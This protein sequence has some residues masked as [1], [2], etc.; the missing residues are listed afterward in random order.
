MIAE[1][2][3]AQIME[4][5]RRG[6]NQ[7]ARS[8]SVNVL[9]GAPFGY[10]YVRKGDHAA[11]RYEVVPHE[12]AIV[13]GLFRRYADE[14]IAIAELAR[15]LGS[16][17]VATRTG[18]ARWDRSTIWGMLRNP[19]Y[20]G[21]ACFGKTG[22]VSQQAGRNRV[23]RL[24][25]RAAGA[26]YT[27]VDRPRGD[28]LEIDVPALVDEATFERVARRL[29]GNKKFASR[30]SKTPSLLQGLAACSG[31]GYACYRGHTTTTAGNKIFYY[32]CIGSGNYRFEHGKVCGSKPVRADYLDQ[33]VWDHITDLIADPALIRAEITGRLA[34]IRTADP[35]TAQRKRLDDALAKTTSAVSR[36]IG[37]YQEDLLSLDELRAR[38]PDL[39]ARETSLRH[40]AQA[41]DAQLA[42][43]EVYLKLAQN[44]EG[45]LAALRK[46]AVS[47]TVEDRQRVVRLL[48]KEVLVGPGKIVIRHSIPTRG[49]TPAPASVSTDSDDDAEPAPSSH[50]RWRSP[51]T[52]LGSSLPGR[53][54]PF[55]SLE[56]PCLQPPGDHIPRGET[57]EHSQQV[58][59]ADL[60]ERACQV[61]VKNPHPPGFP[62]QGVIQRL[63]RVVTAATRPEPVGPGLEPGLPLGLQRITY[64]CLMAPIRKNRNSEWPH[65][66][67]V[68]GFR[69]IHPPDRGRPMRADR[70]VHLHRHLG[71]G[72]AGQCDQPVDSRSPAARIALRHLPHA[73]QRAAPAPQHQ[74]LHV[75]GQRPVTLLHRL[76]DPAAQPPYL[77]LM[78]PPVHTIPGV[79]IKRGQALRSVHRSVQLAHQFRHLRSLSPQRLTCPRQ[80]SFE[81]GSKTGIRASYTRTIREEFPLLQ[82]RFPAAFRPPGIC[83]PGHPVLPGNSAPL[84]VG[85][86]HRLR[87]PAPVVR[88]HSRVSTF[89]TRETRTG[90]GAL[91]T[92]GTAVS[93]GHRVVRGR[94]LPPL[95]GRFLPSRHSHPARDVDVTRHQQGFPDSRPIPVL[96]LAC[97]RHGWS[98]GPWAFP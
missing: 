61:S 28:W 95:N 82:S 72:L 19:A 45:F 63:Y 98:G 24:A 66:C 38:M 62:A 86:P 77:L 78:E 71:P 84:T 26:A 53:R 88:T 36:L 65:F 37:A 49:D 93:A 11:A 55:P 41:L 29:A 2:E 87:I 30:A 15:W 94:R 9:S 23:A 90:P 44:L 91:F 64:P 54:E 75:P 89:R 57:A 40:Q 59:V 51:N 6:K 31:C 81:P 46:S 43:R 70:G 92:P 32:R 22:R 14:G 27:T 34:Q 96:P 80:R 50:L 35:A 10:R 13:A 52:A 7:R 39:R 56:N 48:V 21:R 4:R 69:Y 67:L 1:Y 47:A 12:A 97:G 16:T 74:L 5:T 42:D 73:D 60:V 20:A 85:L 79:T 3:R 68:T 8:G 83:F 76:E 25:G 18:K 17:G 58:P 33:V